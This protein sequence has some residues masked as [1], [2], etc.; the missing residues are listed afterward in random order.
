M[1]YLIEERSTLMQWEPYLEA[2]VVS[3]VT[4]KGLDSFSTRP[5]RSQ[6][7]GT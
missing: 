3:W 5:S 6:G 1:V 7:Q 2:P 4:K